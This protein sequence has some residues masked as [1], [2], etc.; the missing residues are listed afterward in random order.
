MNMSSQGDNS[1]TALGAVRAVVSGVFL[2]VVLHDH[3]TTLANL[4]VTILRPPGV[5]EYLSWKFYGR[6][7]TP[8]GMVV[9]KLALLLTLGASFVGWW[10]PVSTKSAAALVILYEGLLG[11]FGRF[12][13]NE[14]AAV[15]ILAMLAFTPCGDGLSIDA[16]AAPRHRRP[17][18][19]YRYP[20]LLAQMIVAWSYFS[21]GLLKLRFGGW[22]YFRPESMPAVLIN[23][24]LGNLND[25]GFQVAFRLVAYRQYVPYLLMAGVAWEVLFPLGVFWRR[26]RWFYLALGVLMN[27]AFFFAFNR[28]LQVQLAMYLIFIPWVELGRRIPHPRVAFPPEFFPG[29]RFPSPDPQGL[30][31]WDGDCG[32]CK[33]MLSVLQKVALRPV[34]AKPFQEVA[35][36]LPEE[37]LAWTG[38]QMHWVRPDGSIVG[39]SQA[40]IEALEA[41]DHNVISGALES[42]PLRAFTWLAYRLVAGNRGVAG[43]VIGANCELPQKP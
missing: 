18:S 23:Q 36:E 20:V 32:F 11:S 28:I 33:R 14:M 3:F 21:A 9:F 2:A 19:A 5:M 30:L 27:V 10:T 39:G 6:L 40:M 38:R 34:V 42:L 16:L 13:Q 22:D 26:T 29:L 15:T 24:S 31:L 37:V 43:K 35:A 8:E 41:S 1:A 7:M 25:G 17:P 12:S 4:P